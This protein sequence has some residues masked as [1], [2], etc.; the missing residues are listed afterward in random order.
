MV[1][2]V[3]SNGLGAYGLS[4]LCVCVCVM[5]QAVAGRLDC[6]KK[7]SELTDLRITADEAVKQAETANTQRSQMR[8]CFDQQI[9]DLTMTY[10]DQVYST[11]QWN[12]LYCAQ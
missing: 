6:V 3:V 10:E 4:F 9:H 8:T 2:M 1:Q 12:H 7:A 11:I 5:L